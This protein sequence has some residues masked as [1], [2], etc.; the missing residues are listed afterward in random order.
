MNNQGRITG[1]RKNYSQVSN[2]A[3]QDKELT[4]K[5]KGLYGMIESY[6]SIPN[7]ILYKTTLLK[8]MK[9]GNTAF[10]SAW[11]E[12]K[13]KGYLKQ[14]KKR[15]PHKNTY[16]YEYELLE[17]PHPDFPGVEN[18]PY[19]KPPLYNNTDLKNT[20]INNNDLHHL[21]NDAFILSYYLQVFEVYKQKRHPRVSSD[22]LD[23]IY[24]CVETIE[25]EIDREDYTDMVNK[26]FENLPKS[27]NG[28]ILSFIK[29]FHRYGGID[30]QEL[31]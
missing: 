25:S 6:L 21:G 7:F 29:S 23:Y 13:D 30:L 8:S 16:Y 15:I 20:N 10:E 4:L 2:Y 28:S 27:N 3:L 5:A 18:P 9:D 12:L 11:K 17:E 31:R 19:G 14:S 22:N 24:R 26:H 1:Q